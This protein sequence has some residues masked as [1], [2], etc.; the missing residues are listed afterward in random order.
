MSALAT[1]GFI[2]TCPVMSIAMRMTWHNALSFTFP[3]RGSHEEFTCSS[4]IFAVGPRWCQPTGRAD[5]GSSEDGGEVGICGPGHRGL[6][7]TGR[8]RGPVRG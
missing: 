1:T 8:V 7:R 3:I 6:R 4:W 2:S 5:V